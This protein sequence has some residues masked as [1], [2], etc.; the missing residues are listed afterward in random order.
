MKQKQNVYDYSFELRRIRTQ[1]INFVLSIIISIFLFISFFLNFILFPVHV[2]SD[3][4]ESDITKGGAVFVTP[5]LRTPDRGDVFYISRMDENHNTPFESAVNTIVRFL[6][7]QKFYPFGY[8]EKMSGKPFL[9]RVLA[10]PGDTIYMKDYILYIKPKG[11]SLYLTEFE[12]AKNSY[13]TNIYS[14][15]AEW[16]NIGITGFMD[17]MTLGDDE[18]FVLADNRIESSDSRIWGAIKSNRLKGK[19]LMEYFPFNRIRFF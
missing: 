16:E 7:L 10:L 13:N 18:Y 8:T 15:P 11:E 5:M 6:S 17:E 9:R 14:V 1:R 3:S 2:K 12:L 4:M 19:A